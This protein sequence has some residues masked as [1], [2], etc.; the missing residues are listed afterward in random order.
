MQTY[1]APFWPEPVTVLSATA[2][3]GFVTVE[4]VGIRS[5][6]H[7]TTTLPSDDWRT[8]GPTQAWRPTFGAHAQHL[9]L[10]LEAERLRLAF[11]CDPLLAAN[12]AVV[13]LVPHQ[14]EAVYDYMLP[15]PTIR[16]L[17]AHDAGA[18][19]TVMCGL[20]HKELSLREPGL[21]T[22]IVAPS[23]L[24]P[25]WRRELRTKFLERFDVVDRAE[26]RRNGRAWAETQQAITSVSFASQVDV[27]ATL[28]SVHWDLV[29]V[30]EAH[31]MAGYEDHETQAYQLG[32]ILAGNARHLVLATATPHKGDPANFLRLLQLL[33][34]GIHDPDIVRQDDGGGRG[35][36]LML[37]RL[38]E[39]MVDFDG[40]P[41]FKPRIVETHWHTIEE[42]PPELELYSALTEYVSKTYRAA[43]KLGGR[44][45]TNVRFAM[46]ILQRRMGSSFA[47]LEASLE[48][49]RQALVTAKDGPDGAGVEV[50]E[51]APEAERWAAESQAETATPARTRR[52]REREMAE[53]DRLLTMLAR[54]RATGI[55]TKVE[56]LKEIINLADV[57]PGN[58][59]KLLIFTESLDT[60]RFLRNLLEGWGYTVTQINGDMA[61]DERVRREKEFETR[62]QV[63]VATEA[64][65]EGINLQFCAR[66]VNYDLPWVPPRLEQRMGRIHRYGQKR[67]A[68]VYN[69]L[70]A[71]TREGYVLSGLLR[72]LDEMRKHMG[73]Q[74]F[75]VVSALV[76]DVDMEALLIDVALAE[77]T[78]ASQYAVVDR[79]VAATRAGEARFAEWAEHP[80]PLDPG[81]YEALRQASRQYRLTPEYAQHFSAD[82]LTEMKELPAA[83]GDSG[84][85]PGDAPAFELQV[86]RRPVASALGVNQS[87]RVRLTFRPEVAS[88]DDRARLV[89]L[90]SETFENLL[91]LATREWGATLRQGA[92]FLDPDL[93]PGG[94]YLLW[95]IKACLNDGLAQPAGATLLAVRQ[96]T[97][98]LHAVASSQLIDLIPCTSVASIPQWMEGLARGPQVVLDWCTEYMGLPYLHTMR[99][100]RRWVVNLRRTPML[101]DA[102]ANCE[103]A[104]TARDAAAFGAEADLDATEQDLQSA[105][106]R[107][108]DLVARFAREE[109]LSLTRP[110]LVGLAAVLPVSDEPT[111]DMPDTTREVEARAQE[112]AVLYEQRQ[113]RS[114]N[115][116]SGEH[117]QFP[118][119]LH[120][121]GPGGPRC[122]EV[123][124]T[125]TGRF[126]LSENERRA[127]Q[128]LGAGYYLYIVEDPLGKPK[129]TILRDPL[130]KMKHDH[131]LF[132]GVRYVFNHTTWHSARDEEIV[133]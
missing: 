107:M 128:R 69:L 123:K 111:H 99:E 101:A 57:A 83:V 45:K 8:L 14:M 97:E 78:A 63:M 95:F 92:V 105:N 18:G 19:K 6:Q 17:L 53:L 16:H 52:E 41:I 23:A 9:K 27:R 81:R 39:E 2:T 54:V 86:L 79:I 104:Q 84:L 25:Q 67:E 42:N 5:S 117:R 22:L 40:Q 74:V 58:G 7:Y 131:E 46:A 109:A 50:P 20:L 10:A 60:L 108:G 122:I 68:R 64:A 115:D 31:H 15:Q 66:M 121:S 118:Y 51:D 132:G 114:A 98:S 113:G 91:T 29:I 44:T 36:P 96:T 112:W 55:E 106:A 56:K 72:R 26:L 49:R 94:G 33:D 130:S 89:M 62:C 38:K 85:D 75:D 80:H 129:L 37:R 34:P 32:W 82:V 24:V 21:R 125:T 70:A 3:D 61:P 103:Q 11:S 12:N 126:M 48:R 110:E 47:A 120:S 77:S 76:T 102:T 87:E 43:E 13:D 116:V 1:V 93:G 30:D 90:G 65:G 35:T 73:D 133:L 71:D 100:Q 124:G 4:A 88:R 119:D 59:E 28:A 127:A